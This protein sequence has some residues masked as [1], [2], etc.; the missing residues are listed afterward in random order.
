MGGVPR[1]VQVPSDHPDVGR[2]SAA[3][4][5]EM[6]VR[7]ADDSDSPHPPSSEATFVLVLDDDGT[8]L[9]CGGLQPLSCS[10]PDAAATQ[11]EVK[12]VYVEPSARGRGLSRLVMT[13]LIE[14]ARARGLAQ[15]ALETGTEQPEAMGLY[16][17]LGWRPREPYGQYADDPR[18]RCFTLDLGDDE[19]PPTVRESA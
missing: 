18:S 9:A 10:I 11:G 3:L 12:R 1:V 4:V 15:L 5:A 14:L 8:A 2:L 16:A 13:A 17:T 6:A 19:G 7:Y